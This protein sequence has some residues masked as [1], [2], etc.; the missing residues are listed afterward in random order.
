[1]QKLLVLSDLHICGPSQK[2]I[3]L[4]PADRLQMVLNAAVSA[5]PDAQAIVLLGDLTHHGEPAEYT[6]LA[7]I[8]REVTIPVILML[9][10]HDHRE[11]FVAQFPDAARSASGHVQQVHDLAH[12]RIITLDTLDGPPYRDGHHAGLLC[13]DRL[14]F[15]DEALRTRGDRKAVIFMHHPPFTTGVPGMDAINL[16][17][18][19][20]VLD[21]LAGHGNLHLICGH[22]HL[23]IAGQTNGVPWS[24]LKS[25]CHQGIVDLESTN[26][27]LSTDEAGSYG[28][29]LLPVGGVIL[30]SIDVGTGAQQFGGYQS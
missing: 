14:R 9:G 19:A 25:P 27:H 13:A 3:G 10:N 23:T 11:T 1:M 7:D 12:H 17:N 6:V 28:L 18:G 24:V 30:H 22:L 29:I 16:S 2:I 4:E 20:A 21:L 26:A 8:V 15:L 5:H